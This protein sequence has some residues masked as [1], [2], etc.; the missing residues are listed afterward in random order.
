MGSGLVVLLLLASIATMGCETRE[1]Q[2]RALEDTEIT[3]R[4]IGVNEFSSDVVELNLT[5]DIYNPN[6]VTA[7]LERMNYTVYANDVSIGNGSFEEPVEIPPDE[8]RRTSTNFTAQ[9][10]LVP[11]AIFSALGQGEVVWTIEGVMYFDTPLG[12]I[13]QTFS[14]NLSE[15]DNITESGDS[16][17]NGNIPASVTEEG[18]Q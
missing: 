9:P 13:E 15:M 17:A 5:L 4:N 2:I 11:S 12:T 16:S 7:R 18:G 3:V 1:E 8:G 6:D 14:E 10:T